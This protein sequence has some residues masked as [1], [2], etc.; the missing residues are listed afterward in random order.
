MMEYRWFFV[1][2]IADHLVFKHDTVYGWIS[3][4]ICQGTK[5]TACGNLGKKRLTSGCEAD[6]TRVMPMINRSMNRSNY[7]GL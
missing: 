6:V 2:G 3:E 7:G 4:K 1:Y 5:S